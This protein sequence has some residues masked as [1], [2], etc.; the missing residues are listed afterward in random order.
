MRSDEIIGNLESKY[1]NDLLSKGE[2]ID[3]RGFWDGRKI[4]IFPN[5]IKKAEGSAMVKWGDTVVVAGVKAQLGP[6]FP[7]TP[8]QGVVSVNIELSPISSPSRE[9][10]P[11]GPEA[12]ELARIVD[13]GL[14]ESKVVP[15]TD[16]KLCV[17]PGE[18]VWILFVDIY[19][20]DDSGNLID[21]S[22]L[23]AMSALTN[24]R[25]NKVA[26]DQET[27][28]VTLLEET[29]PLPIVGFISSLTYAKVGNYIVYD[30]DLIEDRGKNGRFSLAITDKGTICS[31]Q[32][33]EV[34]AFSEEEIF[35]IVDAAIIRSKELNALIEQH[36]QI[37][38]AKEMFDF[39]PLS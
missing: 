30:P 27:K 17:I 23:A 28:E 7:D 6:P 33:G 18:Q 11:P 2:R 10:G 24:T 31:M 12:I 5:V 26:I 25:L 8:D 1:L 19:I 35:S 38:E 21:A 4:E 9:S 34:S 22:A 14:R 39:E 37:S 15:L 13:R 3:G 36:S 16:P 32:K 20:I 29:E